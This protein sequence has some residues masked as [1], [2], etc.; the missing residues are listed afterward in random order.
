[1]S[2]WPANNQRHGH[3]SD[4]WEI[5]SKKSRQP[6]TAVHHRLAIKHSSNAGRQADSLN[7][8]LDLTGKLSR[9][10]IDVHP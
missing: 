4:V 2:E 8:P 9:E 6:N 3:A 7:T 10:R 1:M 5:E